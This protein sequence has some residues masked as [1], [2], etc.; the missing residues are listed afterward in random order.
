MSIKYK[1]AIE[2]QNL[3]DEQLQEYNDKLADEQLIILNDIDIW[4]DFY[5]LLS[6][7]YD[8]RYKVKSLYIDNK[9]ETRH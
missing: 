2:L 5:N 7:E 6:D 9:S 3:T 1:T 8:R 4:T